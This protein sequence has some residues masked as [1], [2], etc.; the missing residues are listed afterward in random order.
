MSFS[1]FSKYFSSIGVKL[2]TSASSDW[3]EIQRGMLISIPFHKL[4]DPSQ[5]E[6]DDLLLRSGAFALRFP[7]STSNYGFNSF[8]TM[9]RDFEYGMDSLSGKARNQLRKGQKYFEIRK[10]TH[11]ELIKQGLIL[12]RKTFDR[13]HRSD[14]KADIDHWKKVC[15]ACYDIEGISVTGAFHEN[16]LAAYMVILETGP[17]AEII[18]QNSDTEFLKMCPNNVLTYHVTQ[19]YLS[20]YTPVCYGLGSLEQTNA[21]NHYKESMGYQNEQIKQRIYFRASVSLI[22]NVATLNTL[23][24]LQHFLFKRNYL[25]RKTT[26]VIKCYLSQS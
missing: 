13:Q 18:I 9:C 22:I 1:I 17:V 8:L 10:V 25:V 12:N 21:L 11:D 23:L 4:I 20:N 7:T 3:C 24:F 19:H 2:L 14:P 15:K 6:L 16:I 5:K 26:G